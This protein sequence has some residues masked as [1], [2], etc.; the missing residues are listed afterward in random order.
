MSAFSG[1][2]GRLTAIMNAD[3]ARQAQQ[4]IDARLNAGQGSAL[5]EINNAQPIQLSTLN[6]GLTSRL[7][8]LQGGYDTANADY[9][10]ARDLYNP[11]RDTGL[12]A[13]GAQADAAGLNGQAGYDRSMAA[14]HT[15]PG[16]QWRVDQSNDQ[17]VRGATVSGQGVLS[18]NTLT[19]L[20]KLDGNLA[21]QEYGTF[22][23]RTKGIADRG[24]DATNAQ[25]GIDQR[26]GQ[27]AYQFGSD[28]GGAYG[29]NANAVAGVYGNDAR[30]KAGIY[31]NTAAAGANALGQT[32]NRLI[33]A[34]NGAQQATEKAGENRINLGLGLASSAIG[35]AG[36]IY[37]GKLA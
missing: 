10:Q 17:A 37:G 18:G 23:D 19:E 15:S 11:Y 4:G 16:Y 7:Q 2:S 28:Q 29:D 1:K 22:Y 3:L 26:M 27:N 31:T 25:A 5:D 33:D 8:A 36:R 6:Q 9:Q 12:Q 35:A 30:A 14:F 20:A 34:N 32:T 13:W 21:D 24:F